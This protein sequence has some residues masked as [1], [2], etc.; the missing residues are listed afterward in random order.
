MRGVVDLRAGVQALAGVSAAI[1]T[2]R[3]ARDLQDLGTVATRA[4]CERCGFSRAMMS[5]VVD[6]HFVVDS[7]C[8]PENPPFA[9]SILIYATAARPRLDGS[10]VEGDLLRHP[11]PLLVPR[12][13][14]EPRVHREFVRFLRTPGYVAAP[15]IGGDGVLGFV[16]ADFAGTS[17]EPDAIDREC[18]G[19]FTEALG[20]VFERLR[21]A[22]ELRECGHTVRRALDR[23]DH[24]AGA[25]H[26]A[27][28][29]ALPLPVAAPA[30]SPARLTLL[31]AR[32]REV[33]ELMAR[34]LSN[35]T[36]AER[37]VVSVGTVKSHV[38]SILRKLEVD[39]RAGAIGRYLRGDAPDLVG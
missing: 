4:L 19:L 25:A 12:V 33:L 29:A 31:T 18:L 36:I 21:V 37:L 23:L 1:G 6:G 32:E 17:R 38:S 9:R 11:R 34:G 10:V 27:P 22:E 13:E 2:L 24:A 30:P 15:V 26:T 8:V 39:S 28:V 16:H 3:D 7:A 5:R 35:A 14:D 20:H